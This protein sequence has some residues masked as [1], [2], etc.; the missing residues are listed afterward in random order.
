MGKTNDN[1]TITRTAHDKIKRERNAAVRELENVK[2]KYDVAVEH[3]SDLT[4]ILSNM[5]EDIEKKNKDVE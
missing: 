5:K 1:D 2:A 4:K 3:N